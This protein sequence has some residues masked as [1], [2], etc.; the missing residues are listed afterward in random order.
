MPDGSVRGFIHG[1]IGED[2]R[3]ALDDVIARAGDHGQGYVV[4]SSNVEQH[5]TLY[6]LNVTGGI[7]GYRLAALRFPICPRGWPPTC[8][9]KRRRME[10]SSSAPVTCRMLAT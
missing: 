4:S 1:W 2:Q 8:S 3:H 10:A 5:L 9:G 7:G 6:G